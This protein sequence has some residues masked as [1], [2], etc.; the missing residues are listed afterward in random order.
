[1]IL[2]RDQRGRSA[3]ALDATW[4]LTMIALA[5]VAFATGAM[6]AVSAVWGAGALASAFLGITKIGWRPSHFAPA[7]EWW[8]TEASRLG[9]WLGFG[10]VLYSL[11]SYTS[12]LSVAGILGARDYGGLR[13]IHSLFAPLTMLAPAVSL[14]GL[15]LVSRRLA[16][17]T[18]RA[19]VA[20]LKIGGFVT[21][22]TVVYL[23][24]VALSPGLLGVLFGPGF[25]DFDSIILPVGLAQIVA[26]PALGLTLLLKAQQRGR[27]LF[28]ISILSITLSLVATVSA[29][30]L[31]GLDGAVWGGVVSAAVATTA[32]AIVVFSTDQRRQIVGVA[33]FADPGTPSHSP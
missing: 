33:S 22:V 15:P 30:L 20:S 17:S 19:V 26:A 24:I 28:S 13:A 2:F 12:V 29:A 25:A 9:R 16:E 11:V 7:L 3:V 31:W 23:A 14:P 8:R 1:V 27:A 4:L 32:L 21:I 5:P 18:R 10:S 6:W